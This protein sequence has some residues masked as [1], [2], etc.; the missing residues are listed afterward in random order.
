MNI[1]N[2]G[3]KWNVKE[4][5]SAADEGG[6]A[7]PAF[8]YSDI[9]DFLA[10]V[11]AAEEL[12]APIFVASTLQVVDDFGIELIGAFVNAKAKM[13]DF[14]VIH[15]LDHSNDPSI[16]K[17]AIKNNYPSVMMDASAKP[18]DD[19]IMIVKNIVDFAHPRGV[20]VEGE[21]GRIKGNGQE[22]IYDGKDFLARV[23]DIERFVSETGVDSLAPAIGTAHGFYQGTPEIHFNLLKEI[24][25]TVKIPLVLHGGT[26]ISESDIKYA[27]KNGI[28]KVNVGTAIA[29]GY[30]EA[31][32]K[33]T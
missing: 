1:N 6:F 14:P 31:V 12:N 26:G 20:F 18:L 16:C 28:N 7:I 13:V 10:I 5:L 23:E 8:N 27:I 22:G 21:V 33:R 3:F 30:M 15:H 11:E 29:C 24:N 25:S 2:V 32:K 4:I 19:N 17:D 9:W